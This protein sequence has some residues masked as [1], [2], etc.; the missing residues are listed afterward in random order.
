MDPPTRIDQRVARRLFPAGAGPEATLEPSAPPG[1]TRVRIEHDP[2]IVMASGASTVR[3]I[4]R[5]GRNRGSA[6]AGVRAGAPI[7]FR[8]PS[9]VLAPDC[10]LNL[11]AS[12]D[13]IL[14]STELAALL[15]DRSRR[16]VIE[17]TEHWPEVSPS[18]GVSGPRD[19]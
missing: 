12:P 18:P 4:A 9:E 10:L 11:N 7:A 19:G 3:L 15:R 17:V 14:H 8:G 16:I 1:L 6:I 2:F 13:L 5:L